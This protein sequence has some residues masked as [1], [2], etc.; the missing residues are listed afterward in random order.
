[1]IFKKTAH[2][3]FTCM[4]VHMFA[5]K[6]HN[7]WSTVYLQQ[8]EAAGLQGK[9]TELWTQ[10]FRSLAGIC[11]CPDFLQSL[12]NKLFYMHFP[13]LWYVL[14]APSISYFFHV[15]KREHIMT[16]LTMFPPVTQSFVRTNI[17]CSIPFSNSLNLWSSFHVWI[18][19]CNHL[20]L[21]G[22]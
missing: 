9:Q 22:D 21:I 13:S 14:H 12:P 4:H 10:H 1:V 18:T 16:L 19:K 8:S 7:T 20:V 15:K 5:W 3:K 11:A 6:Q 2:S 17:L